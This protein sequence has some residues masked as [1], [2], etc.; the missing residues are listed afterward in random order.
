M[1]SGG[2]TED[3]VG[4]E[5]VF[6]AVIGDDGTG[7]AGDDRACGD[8]I[9]LKGELP[10]SVKS[11]GG[12][13]TQII[14]GGTGSEDGSDNGG[15]LVELGQIIVFKSGTETGKAGGADGMFNIVAV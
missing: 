12:N 9:F 7:F 13:Q 4:R 2:G 10:V 11:A 14:G 15:K 1:Q 3:T 8:I 6:I 5:I